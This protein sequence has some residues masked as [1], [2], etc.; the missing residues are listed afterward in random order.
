MIDRRGWRVIAP[1]LLRRTQVR[2]GKLKLAPRAEI[3]HPE[4]GSEIS[5]RQ[6]QAKAPA[7]F[8]LAALAAFVAFAQEGDVAQ[9][10]AG[11]ALGATPMM[12]DLQELC[13]RIGGRPTGSPACER[14]IEWAAAKFKAAGVDVVT[15]EPFTAPRRWA[16]VSAEARCLAPEEFAIRLVGAPGSP[17]TSG[18]LE[19]PLVDA[20]EGTA[21]SFAKLGERSRGA[22]AL[23]HNPEM[24][25]FDDLFAEYLKNAP[26]LAAAHQAQVAALLIQSSR[27]RGLLY[28][29]PMDLNGG[30]TAMPVAVISREHAARLARLAENGEVRVRLNLVNQTGG[31]YESRNVIGEIRGRERPDE[32]VL[33]G[34]HL[35]SWDLGTGAED[36]GVNAAMVIDAARGIRELQ[37]KP[38]RTIRFVLFT[39][40]EQGMWGSAG[41]VKRHAAEMDGHVAAVIFDTG[42]GRTTGFYLSG[43]E[44][45]RKPLEKALAAVAGLGVFEN[46]VEGIDG[47]DNFDFLLSGVPNLVANQDAIPYLPNYHA[48]SD[49]FDKV[50]EREARAN[51]A[52]ATALVWKLADDPERFGRRLTRAEVEKLVTDTKLDAQMKAFGQWDDFAAGRRGVSK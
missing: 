16:A 33:L 46:P 6:R 47:T 22:I 4:G 43:R 27:P 2:R 34:A 23:V 1:A 13:D 51:A 3:Q 9:R 40:E 25:T 7:F 48:E 10:L 18:G 8:I 30:F 36:N 5:K 28:R 26:L 41:Y 17:S 11:R 50:N 21:E 52:I 38:R 39:G 15:T 44:D 20:G 29:H 19:A 45:L 42:S 37:A 14:A 49:T 31:A 24:K 32:I 35:D 12:A